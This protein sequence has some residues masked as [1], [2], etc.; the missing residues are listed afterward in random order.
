MFEVTFK[1]REGK[2]GKYDEELKEKKITVG[3]LSEEIPLETLAGK[4]MAQFARR[5]I[6]VQDVQIFE[7]VK[8]E[9]AFKEEE[10][11]IRIKNKRFRFDDGASVSLQDAPNDEEQLQNLLNNPQ[12]LALLQQ[13]HQLQPHQLLQQQQPQLLQPHQLQQKPNG[14]KMPQK[15]MIPIKTERY[16]PDRALIPIAQ[17]KGWALTIGKMYAIFEEKPGLTPTD[18]MLYSIIDDNGKNQLVSDRF[19]VMPPRLSMEGQFVE[20]RMGT[21]PTGREPRLDWGGAID[22]DMPSLR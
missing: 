11:G 22:S 2:N 12:I 18:G 3:Q 7:Y 1:Y 15:N 6:L 9:V 17:K 16:D 8:K 5:N 14:R 10:D 20:D 4:V 19:F 13:S 21:A